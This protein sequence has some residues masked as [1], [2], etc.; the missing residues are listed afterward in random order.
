MIRDEL[1]V[2]EIKI[3]IERNRL[4]W[5]RHVMCMATE[6]IPKNDRQDQLISYQARIS[7]FQKTELQM[8]GDHSLI[9]HF[10]LNFSQ[11]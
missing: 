4:K 6:W 3:D 7:I 8:K 2:E 1:K 9:I 11:K 5:Y 10:K